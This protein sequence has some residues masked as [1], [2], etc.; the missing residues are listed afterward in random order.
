MNAPTSPSLQVPDKVGSPCEGGHYG[1]QIRMGLAIFAIVWAPKAQGETTSA[2]MDRYTDLQGATSCFDGMTNTCAMADAGSALGKWALGLEI[3]GFTDWCVP[4]RD[5]LELAYR[6]LKPSTEETCASFR[7][8]DNPSSV[9][10]G[11]PY[12]EGNPVQTTLAAFQEGGDE[13]FDEVWYWSSTQYSDGNAW[14]QYFDDGDQYYNNKKFEARC[15]A[16][17]LIQLT[18]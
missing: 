5:V 15:R 9:P 16:V 8:G 7:D 14:Y 11:Y 1:G 18:P 4:A 10:A 3:N 6:H 17:R 2:W 12:T 13:A